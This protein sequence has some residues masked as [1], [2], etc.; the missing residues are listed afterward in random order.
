[1]GVVIGLTGGIA[2][3]KSSVAEML[4]AR[5]A[6]IID[7]DAIVRELQ[8]ADSPLLARIA[9]RFGAAMI[10]RDGTLDREALAAHVFGDSEARRQL[11]QM[12]HPLVVAELSRRLAEARARGDALI[13]LDIPLL[14]EGRH[15]ADS[16][17]ARLPFDA[18]ILVH[19][20]EAIQIERLMARTGCEHAQAQA[21]IRAQMPIDQKIALADYTID[22]SGT[23]EDT[24]EQV[25]KV[26]SA[27]TA[28]PP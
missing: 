28:T 6:T 26:L 16:S 9:E 27:I 13:V 8:V 19:A 23:P 3:G 12:I 5:G 20:P 17:A 15:S 18:T 1:M 21:R 2:S 4:R 11:E 10:R 7:A 24:E 22:N 14:F 25:R